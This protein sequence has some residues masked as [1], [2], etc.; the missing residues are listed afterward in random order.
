MTNDDKTP[1]QDK[2][3]IQDDHYLINSLVYIAVQLEQLAKDIRT[4]LRGG[5][6]I[7]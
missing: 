2:M 5:S 7:R 4:L 3:D 6:R 1:K